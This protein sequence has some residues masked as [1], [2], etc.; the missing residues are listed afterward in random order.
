MIDWFVQLRNLL[1]C[2]IVCYHFAQKKVND[3]YSIY[4]HIRNFLFFDDS[5]DFSVYIFGKFDIISL[6]PKW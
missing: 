6:L 3:V 1:V 5:G 4:A 2:T